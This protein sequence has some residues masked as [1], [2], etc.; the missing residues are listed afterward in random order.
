MRKSSYYRSC[1]DCGANLDPGE[2]CDC[3]EEKESIALGFD[4]AHGRDMACLCAIRQ[5]DDGIREVAA[6]YYG[7]EAERIHREVCGG[8]DIFTTSR[9]LHTL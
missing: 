1:P 7:E 2:H 8:C 6:F 9:K 4:Q 3:G 5:R